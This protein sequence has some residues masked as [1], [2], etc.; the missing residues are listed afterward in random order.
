MQIPAEPGQ[1]SQLQ[2]LYLSSKRLTQV[3]AELGQFSRLRVFDLSD[4]Q[5]TQLPTELGQMR[6]LRKFLF[7][8]NPALLISPAKVAARGAK[9]ILKY[10]Q[11]SQ[12]RALK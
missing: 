4:N 12:G 2:Q 11:N 5:L 3:P 9:V 6:A 1:C 10:L 8:M 7:D